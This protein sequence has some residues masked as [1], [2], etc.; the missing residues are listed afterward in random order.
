[1]A[2]KMKDTLCVQSDL[3]DELQDKISTLQDA[4]EDVKEILCD[5]CDDEIERN[6]DVGADWLDYFNKF[7]HTKEEME[8]LLTKIHIS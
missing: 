5:I 4:M 1:M 7:K 3:V 2:K 8:D 6:R